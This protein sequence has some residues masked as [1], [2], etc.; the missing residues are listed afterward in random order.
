MGY[1]ITRSTYRI[2][3]AGIQNRAVH[4]RAE[5]AQREG[6][7]V[8]DE[9]D[10]RATLSDSGRGVRIPVKPV[11]RSGGKPITCSDVNRSPCRSEATREEN[12]ESRFPVWVDGRVRFRIESPFK[13]SL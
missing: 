8:V 10:Y 7:G 9:S 6:R 2:T 1:T 12:H 3:T 4:G 5:S 13:S 11:I